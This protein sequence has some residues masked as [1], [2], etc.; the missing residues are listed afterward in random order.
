MTC[1]MAVVWDATASTA[2]R[3]ADATTRQIG[4]PTRRVRAG[5]VIFPRY[6]SQIKSLADKGYSAN[7]ELTLAA[8]T[9]SGL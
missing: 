3:A 6:R 7:D 9:I 1:P 5:L 8:S 2:E 4:T